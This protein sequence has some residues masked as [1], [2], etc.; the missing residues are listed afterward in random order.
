[1]ERK[2]VYMNW[3]EAFSHKIPG[4]LPENLKGFQEKA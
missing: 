4:A 3:Q 2:Q 1:M